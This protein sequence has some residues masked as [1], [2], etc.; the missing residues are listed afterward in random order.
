MVK[1]EF[2]LPWGVCDLVGVKL[3][4]RKVKRRLSYGQRRPIGPVLRLLILSRIPDFDSGRSIGLAKLAKELSHN[5]ETGVL[6]REL[7]ALIRDRFVRNT[8]RGSFQKL[9]GWAPLHF[10]IV[11]VELKLDLCG[12]AEKSRAAGGAQRTRQQSQA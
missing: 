8:K 4:P 7:D 5:V 12:P 6:L 3:D 1:P 11:A 10:R 9:N 2:S